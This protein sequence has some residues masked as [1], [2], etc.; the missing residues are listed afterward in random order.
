MNVILPL[1]QF[2][3]PCDDKRHV[4]I[5]AKYKSC[6]RLPHFIII[7]PQKTGTTALFTFLSMHPL[8]VPSFTSIDTHEEV[9]FFHNTNYKKGVDW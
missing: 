8:L 9:Q 6:T 4:E 2:Q 3:N 7:G 5:W 1:F